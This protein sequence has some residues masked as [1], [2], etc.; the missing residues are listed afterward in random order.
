MESLI[1][2]ST[3]G[4]HLCEEAQRVIHTALGIT[5]AEVDIVDD[6][7]LMERYALRIPVLKRIDTGLEIGWP[8][9]PE[10]VRKF[11]E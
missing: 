9:G 10:E 3:T 2:Y 8:F 11:I 4:C 5:A 1:L 7:A 6:E